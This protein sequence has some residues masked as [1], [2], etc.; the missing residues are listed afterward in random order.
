MAKNS[1]TE[2]KIV[3]KSNDDLAANFIAS[4]KELF[5]NLLNTVINRLKDL[6]MDVTADDMKDL[7]LNGTDRMNQKFEDTIARPYKDLG[8][9]GRPLLDQARN[10]YAEIMKDFRPDGAWSRILFDGRRLQDPS[11]WDFVSFDNGI[12][13]ITPENEDRIRESFV[14]YVTTPEAK[15]LLR[16]HMAISKDIQDLYDLFNGRRSP[17]FLISP[18]LILS[19][20]LDIRDQDKI[21][22]SMKSIDYEGAFRLD[23]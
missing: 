22:V 18:I 13:Q 11:L 16:I 4:L 7:F 3:N 12:F 9:A 15:E 23:M 5:I 17:S 10:A 8:I 6:G 14:E 1:K 2:S 21:R 20:L 19:G